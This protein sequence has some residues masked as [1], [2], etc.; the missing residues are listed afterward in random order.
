MPAQP[1]TLRMY[2]VEINIFEAIFKLGLKAVARLLVKTDNKPPITKL[3]AY[4]LSVNVND[5][6]ALRVPQNRGF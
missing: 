6:H 1:L 5:Y 3:C 2:K 4:F